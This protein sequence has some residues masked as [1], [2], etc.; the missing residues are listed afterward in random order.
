MDLGVTHN[1][2]EKTGSWFSFAGERIG[3][4]RENTR[5]FLKAHPETADKLDAD[6]RKLLDL[7][8]RNGAHKTQAHAAQG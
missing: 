3:Q 1:L 7:R 2:V 6:L 8:A 5:L 4:G